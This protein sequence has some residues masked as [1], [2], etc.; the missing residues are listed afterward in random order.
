MAKIKASGA[1]VIASFS[2]PA[3]TALA[4]LAGSSSTTSPSWW[5][6]TSARTR[7]R[8]AGLLKSFSK[9]KA[10]TSL[11]E[12]MRS[13]YYLPSGDD[14]SNAWIQQFK[15][16]HDKYLPKLPWDGNVLYGLAMSYT[17]AEALALAGDN[18]TRQGIV[19]VLESGKVKGPGL[20]PLRF[21]KDSHSGFAGEALSVIKG[22]KLI[23]EGKALETDEGDG[24]V[25][26]TS[27][28]PGDPPPNLIPVAGD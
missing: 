4:T 20:V 10:D 9:G 15:A 16:I 13:A 12:G 19:D 22:G 25:A 3:Y 14:T 26:E 6:A 24:D 17:F 18:P 27:F 7:R 2:I 1:E 11:I 21:S 8:S 28:D 5:S 23:E